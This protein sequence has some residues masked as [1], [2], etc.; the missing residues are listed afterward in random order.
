VPDERVPIIMNPTA[1]GGRLRRARAEIEAAARTCHVE[2]E[3]WPT[4]GPGHGEE[5]ARTAALE[6]RPL[7]LAYGGDGTYNEVAR[8]LLGTTTAMGVVPGGTTSVLAYEL[9]VPRPAARAIPALARGCDW[10][11]RVGRTDR[12][13]LFLLMLSAGP[14]SLLLSSV[15]PWLKRLGGRCGMALQAVVELARRR[16]LPRL[17]VTAGGCS[18][19]CGWAIVGKSRCY[20]GARHG[21]PAADPFAP[22]F[23]LVLQRA[24]G[25]RPGAG[26]ALGLFLT[27]RHVERLDV[28]RS[29]VDRVR[30]EGADPG[31]AVPYQVDGDVVDALPVEAWVDPQPLLVRMPAS[32]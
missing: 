8:G 16:P 31:R 1:G 6:G 22:A 32:T 19:E 24:I 29:Q 5:L 25:R 17:L 13:G 12:G 26:F 10:A 20:G 30:L 4:A 3:W 23:E 18:R 27:G 28:E 7:V 21:T 2:L 15:P 11:M 9:E 14:D